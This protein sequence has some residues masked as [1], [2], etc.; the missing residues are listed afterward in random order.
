MDSFRAGERVYLAK[1]GFGTVSKDEHGGQVF[2]D[3]E[4]REFRGKGVRFIMPRGRRVR[5]V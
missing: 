1:L 5:A 3:F 4:G 2:V